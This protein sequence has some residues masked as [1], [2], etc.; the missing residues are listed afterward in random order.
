MRRPLLIVLFGLA[1]PLAACGGNDSNDKNSSTSTPVQSAQAPDSSSSSSK[2]DDKGKKSGKDGKSDSQH[3]KSK[4]EAARIRRQ[5]ASE[6]RQASR[7][8]NRHHR[9]ANA[10]TPTARVIGPKPGSKPKPGQKAPAP[11]S[12]GADTQLPQ[13]D[14]GAYSAAKMVCAGLYETALRGKTNEEAARDYA[15]PWPKARQDA[16]YKGCLEGLKQPRPNP[17]DEADY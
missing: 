17:D 11:T 6:R 5:L 4:K 15:R 16:A 12:P 1:V 10:K 7:R 9:R 3:K 2:G 14:E 13:T 8:V